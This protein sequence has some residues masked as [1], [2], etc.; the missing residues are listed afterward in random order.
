MAAGMELIQH[1]ML[2]FSVAAHPVNIAYCLLGV[3]L[4]TF[5]GV[6]PGI[7]PLSGVAMLLPI[8]YVMPP[9]SAI[10]MLA[11]IFYGAQYGGSITSIL[12]NIPGDASAAVTCID[13]HAMAA[14]GRAGA[15]LSMS[16]IASFA[17]GCFST[18]VIM[19]LAPALTDVALKFGPAEYFSLMVVGLVTAVTLAHGSQLRGLA[20]V[21]LGLLLGLVGTDLQTGTLRFTFGFEKLSDGV[22]LVALAIGLFGFSHIIYN[23][24][25]LVSRKVE[26]PD[27]SAILPTL[28]DLKA[29]VKPIMRGMSVGSLLG[30]LPG[31]GAV[32]SSFTAYTIEKRL[33]SDPSRFGKGAIEGVAAPEAANNA[34]SQ[35]SFIPLLTLGIPPNPV[36]ALIGGALTV[37]GIIPGPQ[38]ISEQPDLF[39][40]VIASM[41]IG[42]LMLIVLN[43]P[44]VG[45]WIRLLRVPRGILFPSII[46]FSCI[47]VYSVDNSAFEVGTAVFFGLIGYAFLKF[48]CEP[49]PLLLGFVLGP[50][51]E[52][53]LRRAMLLS[54]GDPTVFVTQP[55]SLV[56]L[57]VAVGLL[58]LMAVSALSAG[59]RARDRRQEM[60]VKGPDTEPVI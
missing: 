2:G 7:G 39:W 13:G 34:A 35:T 20:M 37:Q 17:G 36:I 26:M 42:N 55:I 47:G 14:K 58:V 21:V 9:L 51:M 57:L 31:G 18:L 1:M 52:Q 19:L 41:W 56:L 43:M 3:T 12:M 48:D 29:C 46:L 60:G 50:M 38:I 27:V 54:H 53:N 22:N 10:I 40:G 5:I 4:G 16:K 45:I 6:L 25:T 30:V 49:G 32:L 33:A 23:M 59:R 24:E 8:T 11:G 15:A 28:A 44:L